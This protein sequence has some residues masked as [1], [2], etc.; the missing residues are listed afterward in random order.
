IVNIWQMKYPVIMKNKIPKISK[1]H[2]Y[3]FEI[4]ESM[5]NFYNSLNEKD[6]RRYAGVEA[7]KIGHGGQNYIADI[8]GCSRHTVSKGAKEVTDLP[9]KK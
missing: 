9:K 8:L 5:R 4:E 1:E 6:R 2:F 7:L 3:N